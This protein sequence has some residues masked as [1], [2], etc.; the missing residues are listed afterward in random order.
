MNSNLF[1]FLFVL[2]FTISNSVLIFNTDFQDITFMTPTKFAIN[3]NQSAYF[4]YSLGENKG[5][6]GLKF[7]H[8][9]LYT[10]NISI[11]T[12]SEE[13]LFVNYRIADNQFKEIDVENFSDYVYI[14]IEQTKPEYYYDDYLTI[15]DSEKRINLEH[16]K[17]ISINNF[18]S[19]NK[20]E[21]VYS[22]SNKNITLF[23][24]THQNEKDIR[25]LTIKKNDEPIISDYTESTFSKFINLDENDNLTVTVVNNI[26][27]D[28][29]DQ[30]E[31]QEFSI[32]IY[33]VEYENNSFNQIEQNQ[34]EII[35]YIY[36]NDSQS[37]YF[38]SNISN[39]NDWNTFN[40]RLNFEYFNTK[41]IEVLSNIIYL[42]HPI[43]QQD[44]IDN[45]PEV[46]NSPI[47]Y[48]DES[49]EYL[50]I[51][52]NKSTSTENYAYL[53]VSIKINDTNYYYGN[54]FLEISIGNQV[55]SL[56]YS[57]INYNQIQKFDINLLNYIPYY[58][59]LKLDSNEMYLLSCDFQNRFIST[60]II[61][62]LINSDNSINTNYL[63]DSNEVIILSNIEDLTIKLFGPNKNFEF[64]IE[65]INNSNL[66]YKENERNNND[67]FKLEM[68]K[69][70]IKYILGTYNYEDYAFGGLKVNYYAV[71][72]SG[73]F[74]LYY[75]NNIN[76][77]GNSFF[78]SDERYSQGFNEIIALETNLD[79]FKIVCEA[80]GV[81][82]I[83]PQYKTFNVTTHLIEENGHKKIAMAD[84]SEV[85][86]LS[87]PLNKSNDKLY[88]SIFFVKS[89]NSFNILKANEVTLNISPDV[90][91]AFNSGTI[92][93]NETFTES[94]DLAKYKIDELAIHINSNEF[95]N[96]IEI[97]EII[98]NNY[99]T[100][101]EIKE[102]ENINISSYNAL[103]P[104]SSDM[105][106]L[107]INIENLKGKKISYGIIKSPL[108]NTD[109]ITT[110]NK[111]E[112]SKEKEI[113]EENENIS[114][115]NTYYKI[116]DELRP[117][118]FFLLSI[119]SRDSDLKYNIK[120]ELKEEPINPTDKSNGNNDDDNTTK[121]VII[122]VIIV[123]VL[124]ILVGIILFNYL[125]K[126]KRNS[127]EIEKI[128]VEPII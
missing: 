48:D 99:T 18:L 56:D 52:F 86:Q 49:D 17:V 7:L 124:L 89:L 114:L 90:E 6:I 71:I 39:F 20:Y 88:F 120:I 70:D 21:F 72:D 121:I 3:Y 107:N 55:Q 69:D 14:K 64:T 66:E 67:I 101:K 73:D 44:L 95:N 93:L 116:N 60:L 103:F 126:K 77:N 127:S 62:D 35:N 27:N 97:V 50:R 43:F 122:V 53:L 9:N 12:S 57:N 13:Q 76:N 42:D 96:E 1:F 98:H 111:Y 31:N 4:K 125:L 92:K 113:K 51:Y 115:N 38:Y 82:F 22:Y 109:Y 24:N 58:T 19:N 41:N 68:K 104:V 5:K 78:P 112:N 94:I 83:R 23:Y 128:S 32:I 34:T 75:K 8:A 36:Y 10:V 33:E 11:Y 79:L 30:K 100:Y 46:Q 119:L 54:R 105:Y 45:I 87:A 106:S 65:K 81:M 25:N 61:G 16:N 80:D 47:S 26:N 59:K 28:E 118:T 85:I 91:G 117:Y 108:N 63:V 74:K 102:G 2:I 84:F 37:Y 123:A 15:Y 29:E 110:A 40:L